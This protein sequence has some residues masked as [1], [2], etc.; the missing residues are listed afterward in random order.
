MGEHDR[1]DHRHEEDE[2]SK[3]ER[4]QVATVEQLPEGDEIPVSRTSSFERGV[5]AYSV[6]EM[7]SKMPVVTSAT[8]EFSI[9]SDFR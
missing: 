6:V 5:Y 3:L 9:A 7:L 8:F 4:K 2:A 1:A